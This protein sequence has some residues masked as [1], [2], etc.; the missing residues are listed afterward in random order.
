M[1]RK[2][3]QMSYASVPMVAESQ[4]VH[5]RMMKRSRVEAER[6]ETETKKRIQLVAQ[7]DYERR[8]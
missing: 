7:K 3:R 5:V 4:E 8:V 2:K 6:G 1:M